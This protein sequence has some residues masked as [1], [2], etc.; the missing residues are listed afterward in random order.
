MIQHILTLTIIISFV[1][2]LEYQ[3]LLFENGQMHEESNIIIY[4]D[5]NS[6]HVTIL[7]DDSNSYDNTLLKPKVDVTIEGTPQKD[8][9]RGGGGGDD[10]IEGNDGSDQLKGEAGNDEIDGGKGNDILH[11][12]DGNDKIRGGERAHRISG[13]LVDNQIEGKKEMTSY[14]VEKEMI[15]LMAV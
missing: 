13:G 4:D 3:T 11:G 7:S 14:L 15:Y 12:E 9:I 1:F 2:A 6:E 8:K 10:K 5:V